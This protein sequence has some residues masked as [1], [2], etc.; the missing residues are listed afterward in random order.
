MTS[1]PFNPDRDPPIDLPAGL[2]EADLLEWVEADTR[3][4]SSAAPGSALHRVTQAITSDAALGTTLEAMRVDRAALGSLET[5]APPDWVAQAVLEEHERQA[6]LALSDMAA[7]GPR[8]A[9]REYDDDS[10]SISAMP[11]WF[12]PA[13]AVAAVLALAF[14]AWQLTP[15]VMPGP[16]P[17]PG[18]EVAT[19]DPVE[20]DPTPITPER[21]D[22]QSTAIAEGP[23]LVPIP[24][25]GV[26]EPSAAEILAARLDM[27]ADEALEL[28]LAGRLMVVVAVDETRA[29]EQAAT[30]V[31]DQQPVD[32]AWRLREPADELVAAMATPAHARLVGRGGIDDGIH[33]AGGD[34]PLGHLQVVIAATPT[35][36][37]AQASAS[38]EALL[39]MLDGLARLGGEVRLVPLDERLPGTGQMPAPAIEGSLLWWDGDPAAWQPWAAIPV[40]FIESR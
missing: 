15:L 24:T 27:P 9:N 13:M 14:G 38:P 29:A 2:T 36:F 33:R 3:T 7:M 35:V 40:R 25:P 32:A 31:A 17:Q 30:D 26:I 28:A 1:Q 10:F 21:I 18:P 39:G 8:A 20:T 34:G 12:K 5:P 11:G 23:V 37:L 19:N 16:A 6:L 22:Q 4:R